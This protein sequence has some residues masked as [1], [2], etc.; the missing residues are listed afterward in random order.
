MMARVRPGA[1]RTIGPSP[2]RAR[3]FSSP[4]DRPAIGVESV[5]PA[6]DSLPADDRTSGCQRNQDVAGH[7]ERGAD[8]ERPNH[9]VKFVRHAA[10]STAA[11]GDYLHTAIAAASAREV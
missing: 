11:G 6:G 5:E 10:A 3:S 4:R 1:R 2:R 8:R 9:L 7:F